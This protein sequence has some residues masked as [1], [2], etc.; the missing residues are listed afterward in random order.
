MEMTSEA[1]EATGFLVK[2][3]TIR[4]NDWVKGYVWDN[5][6]GNTFIRRAVDLN[7]KFVIEDLEIDPKTICRCIGTTDKNGKLIFEGDLVSACLGTEILSGEVE[8]MEEIAAFYI[9]FADSFIT[10]LDIAIEQ[11]KSNPNVW[12]EVKSNIH[13]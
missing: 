6:C 2:A 12:V 3:K 10:F 11:R 9:G 8:Y 1:K 4:K 5:H 7:G 13:D